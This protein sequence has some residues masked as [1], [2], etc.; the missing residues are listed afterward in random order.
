VFSATEYVFRR[1][2][3]SSHVYHSILHVSKSFAP[4]S[5]KHQYLF[6][7]E[8]DIFAVWPY[9]YE[10]NVVQ[11]DQPSCE[12]IENPQKYAKFA[13]ICKIAK[14]TENPSFVPQTFQRG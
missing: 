1:L 14:I 10:N 8:P 2:G 13:K 9:L 6:G 7:S 5:L 3:G 12:N 4:R 11:P